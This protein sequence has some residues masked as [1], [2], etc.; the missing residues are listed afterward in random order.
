MTTTLSILTV[1]A[2]TLITGCQNWH[3]AQAPADTNTTPLAETAPDPIPQTIPDTIPNPTPRGTDTAKASDNTTIAQPPI[4]NSSLSIQNSARTDALKTQDRPP[5]R[6]Q[7]VPAAATGPIAPATAPVSAGPVDRA[8]RSYVA[9]DADDATLLRNWPV[10]VNTYPSGH[11]IAGPVYRIMA[12]PARSNS[13]SDVYATDLFQTVL[14]VPQMIATPFWMFATPPWT[15][16][17]YHGD[18]FP[19]SYTVNDP[20]PYYIDERVPGVLQLKR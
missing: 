20:L 4:Q 13:T 10:A 15:T 11:V 6:G 5:V 18:Q 16:V 7:N 8:P 19:P 12:P 17:E 9:A 3:N 1:A 2:A 14:T